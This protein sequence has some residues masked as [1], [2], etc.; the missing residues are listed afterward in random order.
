MVVSLLV[1]LRMHSAGQARVLRILQLPASCEVVTMHA[2]AQVAGPPAADLQQALPG[3]VAMCGQPDASS[4]YE[5]ALHGAGALLGL[6][7]PDLAPAAGAGSVRL[8]GGAGG[9]GDG[10]DSD[11]EAIEA[12]SEALGPVSGDE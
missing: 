6:L 7:F 4:G 3:N 11:E 2:R 12:L 5:G 9:G 8:F 1:V 10:D